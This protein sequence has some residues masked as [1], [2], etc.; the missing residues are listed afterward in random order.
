MRAGCA[1]LSTT[2][3]FCWTA[4]RTAAQQAVPVPAVQ[5]SPYSPP[6]TVV[7]PPGADVMAPGSEEAPAW[8]APGAEAVPGGGPMPPAQNPPPRRFFGLLPPAKCVGCWTTHNTLGCSSFC[9][10]WTF[11]FGSCR[12]FYGEPCIKVPPPP[13]PPPWGTYPPSTR[14]CNCPNP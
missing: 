13:L 6:A 7:L 5:A 8:L 9:S 12:A 10:E 2:I 11:I 14:G 3:L 1:V 4:P